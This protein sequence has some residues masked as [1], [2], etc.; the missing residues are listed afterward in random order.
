M[1]AT[2]NPLYAVP[3][4]EGVRELLPHGFK[5]HLDVGQAADRIRRN[6]GLVPLAI[7]PTGGGRILWADLGR[8][9]FEESKYLST[10]AALARDGA[11]G[12]TF[13]SD[14]DILDHEG[15]F[16]DSVLPAGLLFHNS[17][18]GSTL[19]TKALAR[20][21]GHMMISQGGPLQRGFWALITDDWR[22]PAVPTPRVLARLRALLLAM[23]RPRLGHERRAFVK[24]ISWN[25][26]YHDLIVRAFPGVPALFLYRD[27]VEVIGRV[28]RETTAV[29]LVRGTPQAAFLTGLDPEATAGM[30]AASYLAACYARYYRAAL[31]AGG[32]IACL[33]YRDFGP[34]SL[35]RVV[36]EGFRCNVSDA[37][38]AQMRTQFL[39]DSKDDRPVPRGFTSERAAAEA[40]ELSAAERAA[41]VERCAGLVD[42]LDEAPQNLFAQP[43]GSAFG[44]RKEAPRLR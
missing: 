24:F 36:R 4:D 32:A 41:I 33:N 35:E 37:E 5:H 10:V 19:L 9:P 29:L 31:A 11:I 44:Y 39:V 21:H 30:D 23:T 3:D 18:C 17:R 38:L 16:A 25:V 7:D 28:M 43:L 1:T 12:E 6:L 8:K 15:L 14:I 20:P 40:V 22:R 27:P 13:T 42:C 26:L 2:P 34:E